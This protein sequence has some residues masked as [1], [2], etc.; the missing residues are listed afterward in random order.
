MQ[1]CGSMDCP[2]PVARCPLLQ[3]TTHIADIMLSK[4]AC[5]CNVLTCDRLRSKLNTD[6]DLCFALTRL[7]PQSAS[8][9][10]KLKAA[11]FDQDQLTRQESLTA[12]AWKTLQ[13]LTVCHLVTF[14]QLTEA[15]VRMRCQPLPCKHTSG[16]ASHDVTVCNST[17]CC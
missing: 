5:I 2:L 14:L 10:A 1:G 9:K 8:N 11:S 6:L 15:D 4:S 16:D 12:A 3:P 7:T 17:S 13:W